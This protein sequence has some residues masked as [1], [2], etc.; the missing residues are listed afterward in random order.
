MPAGLWVCVC[1]LGAEEGGEGEGVSGR[2][3]GCTTPG[4]KHRDPTRIGMKA[5]YSSRGH[6]TPSTLDE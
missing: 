1:G 6:R 5:G 2:E 3:G 4:C